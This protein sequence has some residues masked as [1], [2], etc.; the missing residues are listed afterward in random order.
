[1]FALLLCWSLLEGLGNGVGDVLED[2][3]RVILRGGE[4]VHLS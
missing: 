2:V 4:L 1:M 3:A